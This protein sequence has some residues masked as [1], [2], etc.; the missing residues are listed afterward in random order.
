VPRKYARSKTH[1]SSCLLIR[2]RVASYRKWRRVFDSYGPTRKANGSRGGRVFL[3]VDNT[4]EVVVMLKWNGPERA[5][6]FAES[7]DLRNMLARTGVSDMP[8]IYVLEPVEK[9]VQ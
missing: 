6:E 9:I 5:R 8:D 2:H 3:N 4:R 1:R 7:D